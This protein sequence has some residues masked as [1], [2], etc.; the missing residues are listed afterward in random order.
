MGI[1]KQ[2]ATKMASKRKNHLKLAL[3]NTLMKWSSQKIQV[4]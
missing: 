2:K 1:Q 3:E 4:N